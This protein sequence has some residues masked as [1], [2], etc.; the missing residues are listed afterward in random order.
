MIDPLG[1]RHRER[2]ARELRPVFT[3]LRRDRRERHGTPLNGGGRLGPAEGL[4]DEAAD[5][6]LIGPICRREAPRTLVNDPK[7]EAAVGSAR[8]RFDRAVFDAHGLVLA[9]DCASVG[10]RRAA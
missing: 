1:E 5:R 7:A 2:V 8:D 10:V 3:A 6:G 4:V 9:F